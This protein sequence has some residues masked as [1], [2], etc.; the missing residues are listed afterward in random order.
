M[1]RRIAKSHEP[2]EITILVGAK[3]D[4]LTYERKPSV[5]LGWIWCTAA[6]G[7]AAWLQE[8]WVEIHGD[9]CFLLKDYNSRELPV[10]SDDLVAV[11]FEESGWAWVHSSK[12][13]TGWVPLDCLG[14]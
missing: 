10:Q 1:R 12:Y 4:R 6:S 7:I 11:E 8:S 13:G 3:G 14:E 5:Y 2:E 9:Y